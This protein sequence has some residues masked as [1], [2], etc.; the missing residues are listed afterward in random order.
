MRV[1]MNYTNSNILKLLTGIGLSKL[2]DYIYLIAINVWIYD[3]T[4]SPLAVGFLWIIPP[5]ASMLTNFWIG[6]IVDRYNKRTIM[7]CSDIARG[8]LVCLIPLFPSITVTYIL[9]FLINLIGA[10]FSASSFPY[11]AKCIPAERRKQYNAIQGML[12]TGAIAVGP[13]I[14]SIILLYFNTKVA[15]WINAVSFIISA[16]LIISLPN[17]DTKRLIAKTNNSFSLKSD[18]KQVMDYMLGENRF[19]FSIYILFTSIIVLG[20]SLDSQ[21]VLFAKEVLG[22]NTSGYSLLVSIAGVGYVIG[23]LII[24]I[25]EKVFTNNQLVKRMFST[26][27][28]IR[29]GSIASATGFLLYAFSNGFLIAAIGFVILGIGQCLASIGYVTYLQSSIP[30]EKIGR[31]N[32][33]MVFFQSIFTVSFTLL[34]GTISHWLGVKNMT[35]SFTVIIFILAIILFKKITSNYT[36]QTE[37]IVKQNA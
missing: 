8:I 18:W 24:M 32:S 15:I 22:L 5:L 2:G 11:T 34:G 19:L 31:I 10:A 17:L 23:S 21:E 13:A 28:L 29:F 20:V 4:K 35:I 16:L 37:E 3:I 25:S 9:I 14:S 30:L 12:V 26:E 7:I 36:T 1:T 6:G 33:V 27:N